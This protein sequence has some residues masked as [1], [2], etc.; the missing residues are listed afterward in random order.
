MKKYNTGELTDEQL[1]NALFF[2]NMSADEFYCREGKTCHVFNGYPIMKVNRFKELLTD[3]DEEDRL[4]FY[5]FSWKNESIIAWL[6]WL[7]KENDISTKNAIWASYESGIT[8][9]PNFENIRR[10]TRRVFSL[11]I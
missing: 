11:V 5:S 3:A 6:N 2:L 4:V 7:M 1:E 8:P 10:F 9:V